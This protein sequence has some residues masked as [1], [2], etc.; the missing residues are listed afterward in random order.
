M[1]PSIIHTLVCRILQNA[2]KPAA[3]VL[4]NQLKKTHDAY[5]VEQMLGMMRMTE[6]PG[7]TG[8]V[9]GHGEVRQL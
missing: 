1:G 2:N 7:S 3:Q 5:T 6:K 8:D 4:L 9:A